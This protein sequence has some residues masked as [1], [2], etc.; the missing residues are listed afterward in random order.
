VPD[1]LF[2]FRRHPLNGLVL[3]LSQLPAHENPSAA[4]I[5]IY[6]ARALRRDAARPEAHPLHWGRAGVWTH[7]RT[8]RGGAK[9]AC[10]SGVCLRNPMLARP[11]RV[12]LDSL[13]RPRRGRS[14]TC[15][16]LGNLCVRFSI[17]AK[18]D[19]RCRS[20]TM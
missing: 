16:G 11:E 9:K 4:Q 8:H 1:P 6:P 15:G 10:W 12:D 19:C 13:V 18:L 5:N 3:V 2:S 14:T 20:I 17:A 7:W